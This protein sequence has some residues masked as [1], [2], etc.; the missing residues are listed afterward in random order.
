MF[1]IF[2]EKGID[3]IIFN[4]YQPHYNKPGIEKRMLE[5]SLREIYRKKGEKALEKINPL[6]AKLKEFT[7]KDS[8][9]IGWARAF[10]ITGRKPM[11]H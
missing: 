9:I 10:Q 1:S 2:S 4:I 7:S 5:I 11:N 8:S 3:N 6:L